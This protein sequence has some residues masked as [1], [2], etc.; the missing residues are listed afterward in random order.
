M[1]FYEEGLYVIGRQYIMQKQKPNTAW[2]DESRDIPL[3]ELINNFQIHMALVVGKLIY[4]IERRMNYK[5][6]QVF[7]L[8]SLQT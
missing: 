5:L 7:K 2:R 6:I 1:G 4:N 3:I 8:I